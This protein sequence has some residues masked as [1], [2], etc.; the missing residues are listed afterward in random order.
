MFLSLILILLVAFSGFALTYLFA[1]DE[2]FLWR[3]SAGNI[4]GAC[5]FGLV[6]FVLANV[7]GLHVSTVLIALFIT[8]LPLV[9]FLKKD[10]QKRFGR[11]WDR[12][13]GKL[14]GAN[15]KKLLRFCFYLFFFLL[16][17]FFFER[18]MFE[19]REGIFTGGSNNLGDLPFHLGAIF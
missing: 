19:T 15:L 5:V 2:T 3:L 11:D 1:E 18:A 17:W 12:A 7:F 14:Q 9:L 13:K 10:I 16:F 8:L 6:G 4:V